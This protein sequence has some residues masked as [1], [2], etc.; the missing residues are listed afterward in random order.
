[1]SGDPDIAG[2]K[3]SYGLEPSRGMLQNLSIVG[4]YEGGQEQPPRRS[5][6]NKCCGVLNIYPSILRH[7]SLQEVKPNFPPP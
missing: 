7:S 4:G 3:I 1:M 5:I 2:E 6:S